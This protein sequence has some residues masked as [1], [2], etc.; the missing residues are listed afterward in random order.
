MAKPCKTFAYIDKC[1]IGLNSF[2]S[3]FCYRACF[4][5]SS[6]LFL[7]GK[8]TFFFFGIEGDRISLSIKALIEDEPDNSDEE[9]D[10][11]D[12]YKAGSSSSNE[13][14]DE[15]PFAKLLKDIKL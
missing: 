3:P 13:A 11:P 14:A 9:Y 12:E 7:F 6:Y 10:I 8:C 1:T 5:A 4:Q 15:S 2:N